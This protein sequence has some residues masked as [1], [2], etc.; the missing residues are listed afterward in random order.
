MREVRG[1]EIMIVDDDGNIREALAELLAEEGYTVREV[2]N[3]RE[4]VDRLRCESEPVPCLIIVD[5][6][7]PVMDGRYFC[8]EVRN[9]PD[10]ADIPLVVISG[11]S[12]LGE[13]AGEY[14][15]EAYLQK[16]LD[17]GRLLSTISTHCR[18]C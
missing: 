3:G 17:T 15:A 8:A 16:P 13:R 14:E 10:L 6:M 7:M 5:L 4:A 11:D 2:A 1:R 9:D 12:R 18:C